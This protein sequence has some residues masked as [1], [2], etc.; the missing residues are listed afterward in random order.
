MARR[1]LFSVLLLSTLACA[2]CAAD[3]TEPVAEDDN[4]TEPTTPIKG[5]AAHEAWAAVARSAGGHVHANGWAT[6]IGV[7]GLARDRSTH[8]TRAQRT[9]DDLFVVLT[10]DGHA[11][12]LDGSTHPWELNAEAATDANGD[13]VPDV[14]MVRPGEY[15][16]IGRGTTRLTGG[17]PAFDVTRNGSGALPG[18]RDVNHD[19]IFDAA[20]RETSIARKDM[21]TA[22]LFHRAAGGGAPVAIGC[23]VFD[24]PTMK[25][26]IDAVGGPSARFNYVLVD[27]SALDLAKLPR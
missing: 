4:L 7:R 25:T 16:V 10:R 5:D 8:D 14:G 27:A 11:R 21:V 1:A 6:V 18:F 22:I 19:G 13:G 20:E 9:W 12:E 17:L 3:S 23:Q 26:L 2:G 15:V 24:E